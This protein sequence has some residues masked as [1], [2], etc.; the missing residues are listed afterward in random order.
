MSSTKRRWRG[1]AT[2]GGDVL[3]DD[4]F[5]AMLELRTR[6]QDAFN[7]LLAFAGRVADL[8]ER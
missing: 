5:A 6:D 1:G 8:A 4:L 7:A 2:D 3:S